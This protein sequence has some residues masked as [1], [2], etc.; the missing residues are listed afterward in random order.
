MLKRLL[1]VSTTLMTPVAFILSMAFLP[2][3][4]DVPGHGNMH[5]YQAFFAVAAGL[6]AG[7]GIG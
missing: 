3:T 2:S 4:F 7:L 5:N 6:W 1:T